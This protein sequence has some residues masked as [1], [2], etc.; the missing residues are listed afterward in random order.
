MDYM[1]RFSAQQIL[2]LS[3]LGKKTVARTMPDSFK[4]FYPATRIIIDCTE[5]LIEKPSS[6]RSQ[7]ATYSHYKH[8]NT[9]KG[10]IGT[11]P[12]GAVSFVSD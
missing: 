10:L 2:K 4:K 1:A 12:A 5:F 6:I 7:S 8:H 11:T 9:A 3:H